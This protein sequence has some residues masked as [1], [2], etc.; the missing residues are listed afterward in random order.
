MVAASSATKLADFKD[1]EL[2]GHAFKVGLQQVLLQR[3]PRTP[4]LSLMLSLLPRSTRWTGTAQ[5]IAWHQVGRHYVVES[6]NSN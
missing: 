2:G 6:R 4:W 5:E 1:V 3:N